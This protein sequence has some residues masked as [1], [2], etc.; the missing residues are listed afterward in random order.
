NPCRLSAPGTLIL[1]GAFGKDANKPTGSESAN[2]HDEID[3]RGRTKFLLVV[4]AIKSDQP[5]RTYSRAERGPNRCEP[6]LK[7]PRQGPGST[8]RNHGTQDQHNQTGSEEV[9]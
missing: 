6:P 3:R 7:V 9:H 1:N 4:N 5:Q 8:K 2:K